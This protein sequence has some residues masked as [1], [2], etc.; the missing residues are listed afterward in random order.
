MSTS[1]RLTADEY[2]Q[3]IDSGAFVGINRRIELIHGELTEMNPAGPVHEDYVDY[4]NRW[5]TESTTAAD[6]VVR[7]QSSIDLA[8]SRPEPDITWLR[9]GRYSARRPQTGD[10]LLLIEVA[11]SSVRTD[12]NE[13]ADLYAAWQVAEYWVVDIPS[14]CIH[15]LADSDGKV[16]RS[17]QIANA[18]ETLSPRCKPSAT[19]QLSE[20]FVAP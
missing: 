18:D 19:L 10:V 4:L 1:L 2:D 17:K 8:D 9:P 14:R 3:M 20:L 11:D 12:I 7:V 6:C 15:V 16:F 13:K 5:S